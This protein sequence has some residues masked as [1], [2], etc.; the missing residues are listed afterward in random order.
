MKGQQSF[1][2]AQQVHFSTAVFHLVLFSSHTVSV[3]DRRASCSR[4]QTVEPS[5]SGLGYSDSSTATDRFKLVC[6]GR[7]SQNYTLSAVVFT[8][9]LKNIKKRMQIHT[10]TLHSQTRTPT[11]RVKSCVELCLSDA[12]VLGERSHHVKS[13]QNRILV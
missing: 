13:V 10:R 3:S 8:A 9:G 7:S 1:S 6:S 5:T 4:A 11:Q 12:S 2:P